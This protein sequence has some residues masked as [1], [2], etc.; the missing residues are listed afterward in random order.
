MPKVSA[1]KISEMIAN[2]IIHPGQFIRDSILRPKKLSVSAAAKLVG[3]GRPALSNFLNG[4]VATTQEMASRIEVAFGVP[5]QQLLT[6]QS[7]YDSAQTKAKSTFVNAIPYVAPFLNIKAV[8]IETWIERNISARIRFA[9]FLRVLANST[10]NGITKIDF[11]GND[12]DERPGWDGYIESTPQTP[13]I[14]DGISGWEF[15]TNQDV[16]TKADGD[17]EKSV[18]ATKK[19]DRKQIT[20]VFV[21][22]RHWPGKNAWRTK[23]QAMGLWKDVRA[24]DSSDLEQW[25]EQSIAGQ[26]W[27]ANETHKP[28][29][30]VRSLDK[31]WA[32]WAEVTNPLLTGSLFTAAISGNKQTMVSRLSKQPE[33]PTLIAADSAEEALAF[34]AQILGPSGDDDLS[35]RRDR[36]LVFDK[37]EVL[38]KLAQGNKNFIAVAA[39]RDVE[40]ELGSLANSMHTIVIYPRNATNIIPHIV[41]EPVSFEVFQSSLEEMGYGKD[42]VAKYNN[43]SGRSLTVLRR[44][45]SNIPAVRSP[46]W[47]EHHETAAGLIPFLFIGAWNSKNPTD[48]IA[49]TLQANAH[50]Y[51]EVEKRCQYLA[52]LNDSPL[53]SVGTYRGVISKID[54]LFA[55]AGEIT[56]QDLMRYFDIAKMVLSEDDPALDLPENKRWA[57]SIYGKLRTSSAALREGISET[58]VLL[59]V[60]GNRLFQ[61]RLGFDCEGAVNKLVRELLTPLETRVLEANDSALAAYAEAAPHEFLSILEEDLKSNHPASYGLMRPAGDSIF[62]NG[63]GA[64]SELL[65][66]IEGL[67]WNSETLSRAAL[68][69]AQL[70]EIE[71]HDNWVNKPINSL[72]S[73]FCVWMPQTAADLNARLRVLKLLADKFPKV[74]WRICISQLDTGS[75]VGHHSHKPRW[76]NDAYGYGEPFKTWDPILASM[77]EVF[78]MTLYWKGGYTREMLC[79]LIQHLHSISEEYQ[80]KVWDLVKIWADSGASDIDKAIVREKIRVTVL[81]RRGMKRTNNMDFPTLSTAAKA[82]CQALEP[83]DLLNK[84]EWLFRQSWIDESADELVDKDMDYEKRDERI[85][86]RRIEALR[87]ILEARGLTGVFQLAEMGNAAHVIGWLLARDLLTEEDLP[88]FLFAALPITSNKKYWAM[89]NLISGAL[90]ALYGKKQ[91]EGLLRK[92]GRTLSTPDFVRILLLSPFRLTTWKLVDELDENTRR[93]YWDEVIPEWIQNAADERI[94]AVVRLLAVQRP[95]AAFACARLK[96]EVFDP[97]LLYQLMSEMAKDGKEPPNEYLPSTHDIEEA[98]SILDQSAALTLEQRAGLE[99]AYINILS[100]PWS[101][102]GGHGIPSLGKYVEAHPELFVQ[103]VVLTYK[104]K[105]EGEDPSEWQV[106][107]QFSQSYAERGFKLIEGLDRIPG[108]D[109]YGE[110][111]TD[112]LAEWVTTVRNLCSGLGRLDVADL[113]IGNLLSRAPKGNDGV[114]PC[115]SVRHVMEEVHSKKMMEGAC[116]GLY[117]SRG[118]TSRAPGAGGAQERELANQYRNWANALQYTNPF[119]ASELLFAMVKTYEHEANREDTEAGIMRRLH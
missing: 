78:E 5:A 8:E 32:D 9:V 33:S 102:R 31:C 42:D 11:P 96:L 23:Q 58:L 119:I 99:F 45:L 36:V 40:R 61:R 26:N 12:D 114:W 113:C 83:S 47:V 16:N 74:A 100:N 111:Q 71:I 75:R 35:G 59:S 90:N 28:S 68:I 44:R 17:F 93:L 77:R 22:P 112:K 108:H 95:R 48:Q 56:E 103:A 85:T 29:M 87:E 13:W 63:C 4:H 2:A 57:A 97:D 52:G 84:H 37:P 6:M 64:R 94:E 14:P 30:G 7:A 21:T 86:K 60:Y 69:L 55:V 34:L 118:V 116:R 117:N 53:W 41:L 92:A 106:A 79:D 65:W 115:V 20:F 67:A 88:D 46:M 73:I 3:V 109:D 98:F 104:R 49:L 101:G 50:Y 39:S 24:Y 80:S 91:L 81:S 107:P 19:V 62:S 1:P 89:T 15:G 70:A 105:A 110:R 76:R 10:S 54:L 51:E 66:A 43:E 25:L 82:S 38:P 27:F 72:A 18:K